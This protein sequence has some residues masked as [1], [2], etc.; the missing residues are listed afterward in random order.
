MKRPKQKS[1]QTET[2]I[3]NKKVSDTKSHVPSMEFTRKCTL[4][5]YDNKMKDIFKWFETKK[6][7]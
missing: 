7:D 5:L 2:K 4:M 6:K 3:C 1:Y